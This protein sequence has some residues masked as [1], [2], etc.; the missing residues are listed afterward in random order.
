MMWVAVLALVAQA[1]TPAIAGPT[2]TADIAPL[3]NDRCGMCHHPSGSA[4]F[5]LLTYADVKRRATQIADV[6]NR[7]FM[8]PW[9]ADPENGPFIGQQPLSD[10]EIARIRQWVDAGAPEGPPQ[11]A[12][13]ATPLRHW[14][15]GWQLGAPDLVVSLP[16]P[17]TLQ[18]EGTDVFRVFVI[19]LPV[20]RL[21]FVRG[22]E[23][24]PGNP[25]V[26]HH[27]NIRVDRT[28]TSR[29]LDEADEGPG[30]SG[31]IPHSAQYPD[32]HFLGWTP[33][34]VAPLLPA[35]LAWRLDR[36]T[37]LVVQI[38][39]QPSGKPEVVQPSIGLYFGDR[40]PARTPAMLRI[41]RQSIDI[42]PGEK[43]YTITDSYTLPVDVDVQAVQPHAHY[44]ARDV[45]GDAKLPDGTV[46]PLIHIRDWD[47]R[48]QHV[49]RYAAPFRLPKGTTV[50]MRYVYDN[51]PQN[52]RNPEHP[53]TRAR[54][55][56]RSSDEMGDLWI[57]VLTRDEPD[58]DKLSADFRPKVATEDAIGYEMEIAGTPGDAALHDD[59]AMLYLE[60]RRYDE[61][62]RHFRTSLTLKPGS[63]VAH[64][65][66]GTALTFARR[67]D[68]AARE[69]QAAIGIDPRYPKAHNNLG[70]VFLAQK[71]YDEAVR[72]FEEVTRLQ[73]DSVSALAN[74]A[75]AY[76]AAGRF[77]RAVATAD[78]ALKLNPPAPLADDIRRQKFL[79]AQR[80]RP[81]FH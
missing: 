31:L 81:E 44:R 11:N 58:L 26:V 25:K 56:Q 73:P 57:Q 40:P 79:Y 52:L 41:G 2:Y 36:Q 53:P 66:L 78:A 12:N 13:G 55:G 16:Q 10:D 72:E 51:S 71:R 39:M 48:W 1:F 27:A 65:N 80:K 62:I 67:F 64:Y 68:E 61:A 8:P 45:R 9:K 54:W 47:F 17:Y 4:P 42:P 7:R 32:G 70:N 5:S 33:G 6:T 76:A 29:A 77:D 59:A 3:I 43:T 38:H 37:D 75:G 15:E 30:Y 60:L 69:Y 18:A 74:L 35:D 50:S 19:P 23:F 46:K 63:A 34:Q 28:G 14:T 20:D 49:Y 24:R 21:R 22:L